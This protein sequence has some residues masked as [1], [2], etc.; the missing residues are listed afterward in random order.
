MAIWGIGAFHNSKTDMAGA[1]ISQSCAFL[2]WGRGSAPAIWQMFDSIKPGDIIYI[3][4][5]VPKQKQLSIKAVGIVE[6][7]IQKGTHTLDTELRVKWKQGHE[8][9]PI[10]QISLSKEAFRNN[11]YNNTLYE[12]FNPDLIKRLIGVLM[13]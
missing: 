10:I 1:F 13:A 5:F 12:E 8:A 2:G 11:V 7:I 6:S 3:K 4:A 9:L